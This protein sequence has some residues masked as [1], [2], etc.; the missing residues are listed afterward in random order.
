[1]LAELSLSSHSMPTAP[2]AER[3]SMA[4]QRK[5]PAQAQAEEALPIGQD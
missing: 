2:A 3:G 1:M 5:L 4:Q